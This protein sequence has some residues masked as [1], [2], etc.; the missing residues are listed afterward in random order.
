MVLKRRNGCEKKAAGG[1]TIKKKTGDFCNRPISA[2]CYGLKRRNGCEKKAAGEM[3]EKA[4]GMAI[5]KKTPQGV[6]VFV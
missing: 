3:R 4:A 2:D 1:M 6:A 5:K